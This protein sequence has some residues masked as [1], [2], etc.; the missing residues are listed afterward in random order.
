MDG[1]G[2]ARGFVRLVRIIKIRRVNLAPALAIKGAV[3][4]GGDVGPKERDVLH[5]QPGFGET[6]FDSFKSGKRLGLQVAFC[7]RIGTSAC[8]KKETIA[9]L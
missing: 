9:G 3:G 4:L 6:Q 5:G 7:R 8:G 2:G 1:D